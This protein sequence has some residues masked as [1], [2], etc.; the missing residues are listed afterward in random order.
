M[1]LLVTKIT[2]EDN[3]ATDIL[4]TIENIAMRLY[5]LFH[6]TLPACLN[7]GPEA[8]FDRAGKVRFLMVSA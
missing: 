6:L 3:L 1:L 7:T 2:I 5:H 8:N 4:L